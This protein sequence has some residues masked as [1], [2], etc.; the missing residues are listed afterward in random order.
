MEAPNTARGH[1]GVSSMAVEVVYSHGLGV[2]EA[3]SH[4]HG[5]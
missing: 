2:M 4:A 3:P 5:A 1:G